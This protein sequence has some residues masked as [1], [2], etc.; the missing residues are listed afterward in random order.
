MGIQMLFRALICVSKVSLCSWF[1]LPIIGEWGWRHANHLKKS[2]EPFLKMSL[3]LQEKHHE[4][5]L[6]SVSQMGAPLFA[7]NVC[8]NP[9]MYYLAFTKRLF[10][11]GLKLLVLLLLPYWV[12]LHSLDGSDRWLSQPEDFINFLK[13]C[14]FQYLDPPKSIKGWRWHSVALETS[15]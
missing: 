6:Q 12:R 9:C 13:P 10:F 4:I 5:F 15:L 11:K 3:L 8:F 1:S 2:L 7:Y 14:L